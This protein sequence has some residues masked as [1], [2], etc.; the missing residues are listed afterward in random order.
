MK[1]TRSLKTRLILARLTDYLSL[2]LTGG[3]IISF[4]PWLLGVYGCLIFALT[5]PCLYLPIEAALVS[6]FGTTPGKTLFGLKVL[7]EKGG[8]IIFPTGPKTGL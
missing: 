7:N 3:L 2:F 6:R 1:L 5:T 4:S 8:G